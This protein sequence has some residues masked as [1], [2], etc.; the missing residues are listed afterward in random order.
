MTPRK[1][2]ILTV[3]LYMQVSMLEWFDEKLWPTFVS[4]LLYQNHDPKLR[5][6]KGFEISV[7]KLY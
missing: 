6:Y 1:V 7:F 4:V 5:E 3:V 2:T